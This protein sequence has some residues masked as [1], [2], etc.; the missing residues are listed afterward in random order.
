MNKKKIK[1]IFHNKMI[2]ILNLKMLVNNIM[3]KKNKK[4]L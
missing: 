4:K 3:N 2:I 1:Y